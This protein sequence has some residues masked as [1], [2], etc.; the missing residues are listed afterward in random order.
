[1]SLVRDLEDILDGRPGT[2]GVYAR[3]LTP[4]DSVY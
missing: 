3:N 4:G 2:F 1:M